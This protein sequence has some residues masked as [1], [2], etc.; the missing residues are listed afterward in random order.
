MRKL[1]LRMNK[2]EIASLRLEKKK[3]TDKKF[4]GRCHALLLTQR[5]YLLKEIADILEC[6]IASVKNWVAAYKKKKIEGLRTKPQPGNHRKLSQ[7]EIEEVKK[8]LRQ[9]PVRNGIGN[10]LFWTA[11]LLKRLVK[12]SFGVVYRS[13]WS[14]QLLFYKCGFSF[15]RPT[16]RF[17][18]QDKAEVQKFEKELKKNFGHW[19]KDGS[20]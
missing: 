18:K 4:A 5:G 12:K 9:S 15:Q 6:G 17:K 10:N 11:S 1:N 16:K 19:A 2:G 3:A 20:Y 7:K 8:K 13:K 14:Y